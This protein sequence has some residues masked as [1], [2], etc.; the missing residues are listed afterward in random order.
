MSQAGA[1][2][3]EERRRMSAKSPDSTA[4]RAYFDMEAEDY[5]RNREAQYSFACQKR[6]VL[7]ML[8]DAACSTSRRALD[9]G[10]GPGVMEEA[11]AAQGFAVRGIDVSARRFRARQGAPRRARPC[12]LRARGRRRHEARRRR[13]LSTTRC[14]PW[15]CSNIC[16]TTARR[17]ARSTACCGPAASW[18]S[19]CRNRFSPY[20]AARRTYVALRALAGKPYGSA[21]AINPFALPWRLAR[22]LAQHGFRDLES[23]GCNFILFPVHEK[24][25]K[26][27]VALNRALLAARA[28]AA[29]AAAWRAVR[30][31]ESA[32]ALASGGE[33]PAPAGS[34]RPDD[35]AA[36]SG[37]RPRVVS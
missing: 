24:L 19:R 22:L 30:R 35:R 18:C 7:E 13:R 9:I 4:V 10:C 21:P 16:R 28:H 23:R 15:A 27:S 5:V 34:R 31:D 37:S 29:R 33:T 20:H 14:S 2:I 11:L 8:A 36:A 17:C 25:P 12:R 6:L 26:A 1:M 3:W 32:Q